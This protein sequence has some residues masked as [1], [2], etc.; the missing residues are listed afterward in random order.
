M[1]SLAHA[2]PKRHSSTQRQRCSDLDAVCHISGL[3]IELQR[4]AFMHDGED[5]VPRTSAASS[6]SPRSSS[7]LALYIKIQAA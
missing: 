6:S 7:V 2:T 3:Q 1:S 5:A 4:W